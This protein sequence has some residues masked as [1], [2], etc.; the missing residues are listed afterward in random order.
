ME[1]YFHG[2][3]SYE[4]GDTV[5]MA[6]DEAALSEWQNRL[7]SSYYPVWGDCGALYNLTTGKVLV[8]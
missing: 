2:G 8:G 3:Y 4:G 5:E 1:Y 6:D 7:V